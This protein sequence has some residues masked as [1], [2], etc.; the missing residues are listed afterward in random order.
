MSVSS[1]DSSSFRV[2]QRSTPYKET[3]Q[4]VDELYRA[5][6]FK[7]FGI[8]NYAAWEVAQICVSQTN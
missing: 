3:L 7:R 5:G 1:A 2:L 8:S 6:L 4:A